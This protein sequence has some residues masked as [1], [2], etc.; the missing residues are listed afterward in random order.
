[1][2]DKYG[3]VITVEEYRGD[4]PSVEYACADGDM[5]YDL[6]VSK[7]G[8]APEN[9]SRFSNADFTCAS[10]REEYRFHLSQLNT[11]TE[12]YFYYAGHGFFLDGKNYLS[13]YET[14]LLNLTAT[15]IS[16]EDVI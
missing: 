9:I 1:M 10:F 4:I 2:A 12:L 16:F 14:S 15:S 8:I 11:D 6:F 13:T 3:F 5:V 7:L